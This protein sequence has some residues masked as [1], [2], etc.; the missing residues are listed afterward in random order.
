MTRTGLV[1]VMLMVLASPSLAAKYTGD[2]TDARTGRGSSAKVK[3]RPT[4]GGL[5]ATIK[6][7]PKEGCP[8]P[9]KLKITLTAGADQYLYSGTFSLG[10]APCVMNAYVYPAG[11]QG[12]YSC[13]DGAAGSVGAFS[14]QSGED[15]GRHRGSGGG[16]RRDYYR[17]QAP[18]GT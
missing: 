17:W 13:D 16:G 4:A 12:T 1:V 2:A 10:G 3:T 11:F 18:R 8:L 7:K 6:C 5:R 14:G 9:R 15:R